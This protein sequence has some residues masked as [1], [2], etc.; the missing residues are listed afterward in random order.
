M[1]AF[2]LLRPNHLMMGV[3]LHDAI[4]PPS[5]KPVP[6]MPH[7]VIAELRGGMNI[8]F[9]GGFSGTCK[10]TPKVH[11]YFDEGLNRATDIG[12]WIDHVFYNLLIPLI[13]IGSAS[14][15]EFGASTVRAEGRPVATAVFKTS[16]LNLNCSDPLAL[17]TGYV[18]APCTVRAG[19]TLG[20]LIAGILEGLF[21]MAVSLALSLMFK[22]LGKFRGMTR[23]LGKQ[24]VKIFRKII[25]NPAVQKAIGW[26]LGSGMGTSAPF[27]PYPS[28]IQEKF[29]DDLPKKFDD[30]KHR[31]FL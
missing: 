27:A 8:S 6:F 15:S 2:N 20:D 13:L 12:P 24:G 19:M 4:M 28:D 25:G 3:D 21:D 10:H 22:W 1:S 29:F 18:D 11:V 9:G 30:P 26:L 5:L 23:M 16:N 7:F 31:K 14:K 17:P